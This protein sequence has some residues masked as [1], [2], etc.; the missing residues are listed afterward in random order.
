[1]TRARTKRDGRGVTIRGEPV[2]L[3]AP[4]TVAFRGAIESEHDRIRR[5]TIAFDV[6]EGAR[7]VSFR[8]QYRDGLTLTRGEAIA[9]ARMI[10]ARYRVRR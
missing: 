2:A 9:A 5:P 1:M 10:L 7:L 4:D 8:E 3:D 6:F